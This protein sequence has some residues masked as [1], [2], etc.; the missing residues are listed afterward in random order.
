MMRKAGLAFTNGVA[1]FFW[2]GTYGDSDAKRVNGF[3]QNYQL[4]CRIFFFCKS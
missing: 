3:Y 1:L 4:C 2:L